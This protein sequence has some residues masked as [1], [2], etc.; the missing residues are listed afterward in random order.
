MFLRNLENIVKG[1]V[2][3]SKIENDLTGDEKG[4]VR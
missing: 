3:V 4:C 1:L 2:K